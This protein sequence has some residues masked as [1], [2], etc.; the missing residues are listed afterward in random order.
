MSKQNNNSKNIVKPFIK[1]AGGKTQL[2]D[3]IY[4]YF[5]NKINNYYEPFVGGGSVFLKLL[6]KLENNEIEVNN[7][8]ISDLN[9]DLINLYN[10]IKN[11]IDK[12]II[13]IKRLC[14]NYNNTEIKKYKKRHNFDKEEIPNVIDEN[15]A[16]SKG[17]Q[18]LYYYYRHKYN[19]LTLNDIEKSALFIFLN[20]S[21]F[22]GLYREGKKGFNVPFGNYKKVNI[23]TDMLK[24]HNKLYNKYNV[25]FDCKSYDKLRI[26][27]HNDFV[28]LDPPYVP[29]NDTSFTNYQKD[30]FV[31]CF[32]DLVDYCNELNK[33]NIKFIQS[34]SNVDFNL[35]N[36]KDYEIIEIKDCKR[37]INSKNPESTI[38]EILIMN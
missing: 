26:V 19:T 9:K 21:C 35:K 18:V 10:C 33:K 15:D 37:H 32:D 3:N 1:W 13:E 36:Y 28:Y 6:E 5:P 30:G 20:K 31:N 27:N 25:N 24:Y 38:T 8:F 16:I 4:N 22:R 11:D 34:N 29:V 23:D 17:S 7:I 14:D 12:L 2:L